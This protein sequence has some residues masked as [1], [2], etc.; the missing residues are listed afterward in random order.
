MI[1]YVMNYNKQLYTK[2]DK[3]AIFVLYFIY[4]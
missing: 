3:F 2:L 1:D 4:K